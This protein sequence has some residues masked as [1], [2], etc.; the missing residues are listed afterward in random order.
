MTSGH[1][2]DKAALRL[3][4][5]RRR[6]GADEATRRE[7]ADRHAGLVGAVLDLRPGAA[8]TV[9]CYAS[10]GDEPRT[11][12]LRAA[13]A[14]RGVE[15]LLPWLRPDLDLDWVRDPGPAATT[16][17][18]HALRPPGDRLGPDAVGRCG[19]VV[20]PALAVD[21]AGTRLGQ[22]G[23]SYDRALARLRASPAGA[24]VPVVAVLSCAEELLPGAALPRE[25]H[26]VAVDAVLL[27]D[28][29]R[30][31]RGQPDEGEPAGHGR[32]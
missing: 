20:V 12:P 3:A 30:V 16:G 24:A 5:R 21:A 23:G 4:V 10:I 11:A 31:L 32:S 22:G 9:A 28:G 25:T 17:R 26:D 19:V 1:D 7:A 14:A 6:A 15:V 18:E 8:A 27:P 2:G 29:L 13:L